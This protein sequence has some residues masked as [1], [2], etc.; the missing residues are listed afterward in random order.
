MIRQKSFSFLKKCFK[1][2]NKISHS[3][4]VI[5]TS[6][7]EFANDV[8]KQNHWS[9]EFFF[10]W[11]MESY[12]LLYMIRLPSVQA[13]WH[14]AFLVQ[15]AQMTSPPYKTKNYGSHMIAC[16]HNIARLNCCICTYFFP[17]QNNLWMKSKNI[18][19]L[20]LVTSFSTYQNMA[21]LWF[22]YYQ[23]LLFS[24]GHQCLC[25]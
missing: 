12:S 13:H 20:D 11:K 3:L 17:K 18:Y 24:Y 14:S 21:M 4:N 10:P 22:Y 19:Q 25:D 2:K 23:L 8:V 15:K 5:Y 16:I 6:K 9:I 1:S 7:N